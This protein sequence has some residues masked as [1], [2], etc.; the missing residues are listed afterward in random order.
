[1]KGQVRNVT[2]GTRP[3]AASERGNDEM[4]TRM[5]F[6]QVEDDCCQCGS[7]TKT[8]TNDVR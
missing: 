6:A 7:V 1:M 3:V 2:D 8:N 5:L 4:D